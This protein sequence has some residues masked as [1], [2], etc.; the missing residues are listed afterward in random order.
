MYIIAK[1]H[2][3]EK[4]KLYFYHSGTRIFYKMTGGTQEAEGFVA[5]YQT[6]A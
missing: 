2:F 1:M 6:S 5:L 4:H 3:F